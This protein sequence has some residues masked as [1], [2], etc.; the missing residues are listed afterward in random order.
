MRNLTEKEIATLTVYGCTAENWKNIWVHEEFNPKY[1]AQV[2]FSGEVHMGKFDKVFDL[3]GGISK[4]SGLYNSVFH[5]CYIGNDVY[6]NHIHNYMAN[7]IVEDDVFIEHTDSIIC[8][9]DSKFGNGTLVNVMIESGHRAIPIFEDLS[10]VMAYL[11]T[12]YRH[13]PEFTS[14]AFEKVDIHIEEL[15]KTKFINNIRKTGL[16]HFTAL[17]LIGKGSHIS[18]SGEILNTITGPNTRI[19]SASKLSNG[20][21]AGNTEAPV[22][23]GN[24]VIAEDFIIQSGA[25]IDNGSMISR[26]LIGQGTIIDKQFSA[27]DSLFFA[28]CQGYHGEAVSVFAG[29]FTVSHHRSTLLL[30]ALYS[31]YNAGSGTN[32]SNHMYKTGPVHQGITER[33]VKTSSNSYIMWPARIGAFNVVLGTHKGNPDLSKLPFSYLME[34]DGES[35]LMPGINFQ[36]AG[37]ARDIQ[38]WAQRDNRKDSTLIDIYH[39]DFL[40]PYLIRKFI[41]GQEILQNLYDN[42]EA[43]SLFVWYQ[44]CKIKKSALKKGIEIYQIG[45]DLYLMKQ[46]QVFDTQSLAELKEKNSLSKDSQPLLESGIDRWVDLAGMII[47]SKLVNELIDSFI[48]ENKSITDLQADFARA[49][50]H[51]SKLES[52]WIISI[53]GEQLKNPDA[54]KERGTKV[55]AQLDDMIQRDIKKE[56]NITSKIGFGIDGDEIVRDADFQNTRGQF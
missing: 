15:L 33:G 56:Y 32:F 12:F 39:T 31:F 28:N 3:P 20:T 23:I 43:G 18:N 6:I 40:N 35:V 16:S 47:S 44:N 9:G 14:K 30:A 2:H 53:F 48:K 55:Q 54:I 7:Y 50:N 29:P 11:L 13:L 10:N 17:G 36:S 49:N 4:H 5:N 26:C 51:K 45:I 1:C 19:K 42:M 46:L 27:I 34:V 41:E 24:G 38:K 52:N 22:F 25:C 8:T 21:I 37:T